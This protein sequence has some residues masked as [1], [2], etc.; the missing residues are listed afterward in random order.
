MKIIRFRSIVL[1]LLLLSILHGTWVSWNFF[2]QKWPLGWFDQPVQVTGIVNALPQHRDH[3]LRF[4][5]K[6]HE[7]VVELNWYQP[8]PDLKPGQVW[9]IWIKVK[10]PDF[11]NNPG[12]FDY[13]AYLKHQGVVASGY[14]QNRADNHLL[15]SKPWLTPTES[16]RAL[17][18]QKVLLATHNLSMQ[19]ILVALILGDKT[20]LNPIQMEVFERTG[21]SYFMVIS[22][23][24][25]ILFAM[26]GRVLLRYLWSL[27][28]RA[29]L[30]IPAE[31]VGL[32]AGLVLGLIYSI[33]AG[34]LVPTQRALWMIGLMGLARLF[35]KQY[36]SLQILA[37]ALVLVLA[38]NPFSVYSVAFWLSFLAVFFLIYTLG[39]REQNPIWWRRWLGEWFYP[40]W[41]MYFALVPII[42]EVFQTFSVIGFFTNL[43]AVPLMLLGVIPLA[44]LGAVLIFIWPYAGEKLFYFSNQ[45][46]DFLWQILHYFALQPWWGM[47]LAK[48]SFLE[49]LLAQIGLI[50]AFA[51]RGWPGRYLGWIM[52]LPLFYPASAI[53]SGQLKVTDLRVS[54]GSVRIYQ[55][56]HHVLVEENILHLKAGKA[57]IRYEVLPFLQ[58]AG[59]RRVD[60]WVL[61]F[62]GNDKAL[63]S[64]EDAWMPLQIDQ[65]IT[66]Q[67][68][69]IYDS[70]RSLCDESVSL[71]W[72]Q[73]HFKVHNQDGVCVLN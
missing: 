71:I 52:L 36:Q 10:H 23:L 30:W 44:L 7:G 41:V 50:I 37:W 68:Y 29:T 58:A 39:G 5:L 72:D 27:S 56:Q 69:K 12:E 64:L 33:L 49:M 2:T 20:W 3:A 19:G 9:Q 54:E 4:W 8:F 47:V 70:N 14:V 24:H 61:N 73:Q 31:Q 42:I 48:P 11:Q 63:E 26:L 40:Q 13:A 65:I 25:I 59:W 67:S 34:F 22:G 1:I 51:P 46:M 62:K 21:T 17:V 16:L 15:A 6:T 57:A 55:T 66:N 18:Y 32:I 43:L 38:W 28:Y 35:L 45:V 53:Q 60:L